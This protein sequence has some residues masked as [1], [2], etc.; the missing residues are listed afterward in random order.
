MEVRKV[1]NRQETIYFINRELFNMRA[2]Q[3]FT[4]NEIFEAVKRRATERGLEVSSTAKQ[5]VIA[6]L[7]ELNMHHALVFDDDSGRYRLNSND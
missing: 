5:D 3:F 6:T 4:V 7:V 2:G 1:L